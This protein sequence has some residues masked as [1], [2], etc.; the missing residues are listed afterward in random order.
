MTI[1]VHHLNNSRSQRILW[2]LEE[3]G[4]P[5]Q[6]RRYERDRK[7]MRA[8]ESLRAIH[9]LGRSPVV[10]VD[11]HRLIETGAIMEHLVARAGNRFGPPADADGAIRYRQYMHYAEGSMMP[12]LLALLIIGKLGLFGRPAR[13]TVQRML[14][15]HLDWLET[16][17]ASRPYFAG[18]AFTAADMMMSF[19]LEASRARGGLDSSRPHLIRWLEDMQARPAYTAALAAGGPYAYA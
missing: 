3:L 2:L 8:P 12:P 16:E 17:L 10:E 14:D 13:P 9:P 5:Y 19:P 4:E 18:D 7:T 15:D 1:L 11:G 6:V